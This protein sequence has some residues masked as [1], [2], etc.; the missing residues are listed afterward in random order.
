MSVWL[1]HVKETRKNCPGMSFKEVLKAAKKT[2]NKASKTAGPVSCKPSS[3]KKSASRKGRA[4]KKTRR[5]KKVRRKKGKSG[6]G[7]KTKKKS[8]KNKLPKKF[9]CKM[10]PNAPEC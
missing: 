7:R 9:K 8:L 6:K 1:D 5:T 2:Y 10:Y 3:K 4:L